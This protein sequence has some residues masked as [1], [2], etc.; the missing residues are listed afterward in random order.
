MREYTPIEDYC[1]HWEDARQVVVA[2]L[3]RD[4]LLVPAG[5]L[6]YPDVGFIRV[7][8]TSVPDRHPHS[9]GVL[10]T[11]FNWIAQ[12][13]PITLP[14]QIEFAHLLRE[15]EDTVLLE[16][17]QQVLRNNDEV[18]ISLGLPTSIQLIKHGLGIARCPVPIDPDWL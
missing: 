12:Y 10:R 7:I 13:L 4:L 6:L 16:K 17:A 9:I 1:Y 14:T 3:P 8:M 15:I 2:A 18:R 5:G 11:R